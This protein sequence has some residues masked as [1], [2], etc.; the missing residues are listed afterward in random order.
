[1]VRLI[2]LAV[3]AISEPVTVTLLSFGKASSAT[4]ASEVRNVL[5]VLDP[6]RAQ[7]HRLWSLTISSLPALAMTLISPVARTVPLTFTV[8][9]SLPMFLSSSSLLYFTLGVVMEMME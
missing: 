7:F 4:T 2:G 3:P 8:P 1:M 6:P 9:M 5:L